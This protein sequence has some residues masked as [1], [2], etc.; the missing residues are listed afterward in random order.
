MEDVSIAALVER[1]HILDITV[2]VEDDGVNPSCGI[3][4]VSCVADG[5]E[6]VAIIVARAHKVPSSHTVL[7][8]IVD[9]VEVRIAKAVRELMA[10]G[11]DASYIALVVLQL[12]GA[13]IYVNCGTVLAKSC[14]LGEL[15]LVR[16][17]G[18]GATASCLSLAGIDNINLFYL[19]IAVPVVLAEVDTLSCGFCASRRNHSLRIGII[20]L[21]II[22]LVLSV[23]SV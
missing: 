10:D 1:L 22:V 14:R 16:P 6:A 20:S 8:T 2:I 13:S 3:T 7:A 11:A 5:L 23:R 17:D 15:R 9:V 19:T 4:L 12:I 21:T 18:I